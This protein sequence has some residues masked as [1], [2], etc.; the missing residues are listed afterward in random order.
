MSVDKIKD[1][2]EKCQGHEEHVFI[3]ECN[4]KCSCSFGCGNQI[5]QRGIQLKLQVKP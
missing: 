3:K 2:C 4:L 5:V 1:Y